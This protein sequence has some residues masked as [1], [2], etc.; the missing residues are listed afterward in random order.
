VVGLAIGLGL[1]APAA[2]FATAATVSVRVQRGAD[3]VDIEASALLDADAA[4]AWRVLTD[5]ERYVEF[6]PDLRVSRVVARKGPNVTVEQ[7]GDARVWLLRIPLEVRFE[8]EE[9]APTRLRSRAA[10]GSF[11]TMESTYVLEPTAAGVRLGYVGRVATRFEL[12]GQF[13][14]QAVQQNITRQFQALA[15]AIEQRSAGRREET[16]PQPAAVR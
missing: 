5:Y 11:R 14:T 6:I 4:G 13:E 2:H 1:L 9:S 15:D 8:I 7:T 12:F 3:S 16:R 10:A